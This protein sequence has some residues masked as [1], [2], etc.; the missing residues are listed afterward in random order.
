M[1]K[2]FTSQIWWTSVTWRTPN[3]QNTSRNTRGELCFGRHRWR[4]RRIQSSIHEQGASASQMAAAKFL[5]TISK[6]P[7]MAGDT[8]DAISAYT[9]IKRLLRMIIYIIQTKTTDKCV[10][11][12]HS[13]QH[14]QQL[15]LNP[16]LPLWRQ[17]DPN[18]QQ[19]TKPEPEA[20]HKN[21]QSRFGLVVRECEYGSFYFD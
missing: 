4:R 20:R 14:S 2:Q 3:L 16:T 10:F 19:R 12:S 13:A 9:Q 5:D 6:L 15:T 21:A 1:E 18:D 17:S 8:S 7:G 11:E